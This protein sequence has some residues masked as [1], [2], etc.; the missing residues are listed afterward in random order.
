M[1]ATIGGVDSPP[2]KVDVDL[3]Y[4]SGPGPAY[5]VEVA[6]PEGLII[7]AASMV[8]RTRTGRRDLVTAEGDGFVQLRAP[9]APDRPHSVGLRVAFGFPP[10]SIHVLATIAGA[11]SI[12]ALAIAV[13]ASYVPGNILKNGSASAFL[14]APALVTGL[15]LG[16]A[17]TPITSRPVNQLRGATFVI[18][19]L[20]VLGGLT[21]ALLGGNKDYV[22][23][24]HGDS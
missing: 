4:A 15:V 10:G 13:A 7:E 12:V 16:F 9:D 24:C 5:R 18:A 8:A 14:A 22:D 6:A 1:R 21:V 20:G 23:A 19:I 3:P 2:L 17:T 11:T